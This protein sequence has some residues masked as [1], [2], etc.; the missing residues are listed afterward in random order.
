MGIPG[1][2]EKSEKNRS[3]IW[4]NMTDPKSLEA[5]RTPHKMNVKQ[6]KHYRRML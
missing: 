6:T 1:K 4:S 5:Q 2:E 3:S